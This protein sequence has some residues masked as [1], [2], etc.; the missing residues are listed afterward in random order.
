MNTIKNVKE[1]FENFAQ[2]EAE[3]EILK[4]KLELYDYN[5]NIEKANSFYLSHVSFMPLPNKRDEDEIDLF[6][7]DFLKTPVKREPRKLFKISEHKNSEH[8]VFWICFTSM[9]NYSDTAS[10]FLAEMLYII[11]KNNELK[12]AA[13]SLWSNYEKDGWGNEEYSWHHIFGA[14]Y[15]HYDYLGEPINIKRYEEPE[16]YLNGPEIYHE[17]I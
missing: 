7:E 6:G 17:N 8:G 14:K 3:T 13:K 10:N 11:E 2:V 15:L 9:A 1:F 5:A 16:D 4:W 12:I